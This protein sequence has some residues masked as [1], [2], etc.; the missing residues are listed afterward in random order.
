[1]T[2][3][4]RNP[5]HSVPSSPAQG[6]V[7]ILRY[8]FTFERIRNLI[9]H[10]QTA[11]EREHRFLIQGISN[12]YCAMYNDSSNTKGG[13]L[14]QASRAVWQSVPLSLR[15]SFHS[16]DHI[17]FSGCKIMF[18]RRSCHIWRIG[19]NTQPNCCARCSLLRRHTH[20][21]AN[22]IVRKRCKEKV[23]SPIPG[24]SYPQFFQSK[25][26]IR[27]PRCVVVSSPSRACSQALHLKE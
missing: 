14:P 16:P 24:K 19:S 12:Y 9:G 20:A 1:M 23:A 7:H 8:Y 26:T 5:R 25:S 6:I 4:N 27:Y 3:M 21:N 15:I 22:G 13:C 10:V 2:H 17:L 11:Q 18:E